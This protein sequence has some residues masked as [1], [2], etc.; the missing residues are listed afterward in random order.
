MSLL[1]LKENPNCHQQK[2]TSRYKS[3]CIQLIYNSEELVSLITLVKKIKRR[4][5]NSYKVKKM[6]EYG[7]NNSEVS[8]KIENK[9]KVKFISKSGIALTFD[10]GFRVTQW[11]K[12][13][14]G[15]EKGFDDIFGYF[16]VKS[17]FNIN[18]LHAFEKRRE[19]NQNEIDMLLEIQAN[20][21]EIAH[22]GYAH[23]NADKYT[24]DCGAKKW[25][26]DEILPL[27]QW[28]EKQKHSISKDRFKVPISF[29]YPG[30][31]YNYNTN[32][33]LGDNDFKIFR[34]HL[35]G[36]N[37]AEF[38][39]DGFCPSICIDINH[40][41]SISNIKYLM[42]F[43]KRKNR[44][45]VLMCHSIL[46]EEVE[47]DSFGWG[48]ESEL[49][50]KYRIS[51]E[52]L[53]Y[54]IKEA[55]KLDLEFYT[56][57]EIAGI[58]TFTDE[59]FEKRIRK[60]INIPKEKN[61]WI[62]IIDLMSIKELDLSNAQINNLSGIEYFVNLEKLNLKGNEIIDMRI[63]SKLDKLKEVHFS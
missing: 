5:V 63:L 38:G 14:L 46:P 2:H 27:L 48:K 40:F 24:K 44:N 50:G 39:H 36:S 28:M 31:K 8:N 20:G 51:P 26:D 35:S 11:Y 7:E 29:A 25:I 32:K 18:A 3:K 22:H 61:K 19:L 57:S 34:A 6:C 47:W 33:A 53:K 58:A 13:G 49:D 10:D 15:K 4:V 60:V 54:I 16:D 1:V 43:A 59:N 30:S 23:K 45:L 56:L 9:N 17:T 41:P 37:L 52:S 12:Y 55:K 42:K 21:H 62:H